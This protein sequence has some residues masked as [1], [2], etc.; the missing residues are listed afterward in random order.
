[1]GIENVAIVGQVADL[2]VKYGFLAVGLALIVLAAMVYKV[3]NAKGITLATV[4]FGFAFIAT[5]GI[6]DIIQRVAPS[7]I[8]SQRT[9][10]TG[11]IISVN[12]G[13]HIV[14]RS[15]IRRIGEAYIKREQD[16][17]YRETYN[18]PFIFFHA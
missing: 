10:I 15:D 12:Q 2:I 18:F 16:P 4:C 17:Q 5:Y 8:S 7:L 11:A 14:M 9:I 3:W 13:Y 1:M 6:L